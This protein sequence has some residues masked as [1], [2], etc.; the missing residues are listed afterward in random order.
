MLI[1]KPAGDAKGE[2]TLLRHRDMETKASYDQDLRA[3]GQ[4]LEMRGISVFEVKS[5]A[6]QYVVRG[7][8]DKPASF[9]ATMRRWVKGDQSD[10]PGTI[11]YNA[12]AIGEIE[13][14]SKNKRVKS[15]RLPD[16]YNLSNT[17]R[18]V[19][20]Y[21]G[22]KDAELLELHKRPLTV[23]LLYQDSNGHPHMEDRTIASFF[24][25]FIELHGRRSQL[26]G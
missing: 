14:Q 22:S 13:Q 3:I 8:P 17:L 24:N 18:T 16:F 20:A 7:T 9:I 11:T 12:Q 4:A 19:G 1:T 26:K 6:N 25:V 23:T 21:L 15:G 2:Q 10:L 5:Q